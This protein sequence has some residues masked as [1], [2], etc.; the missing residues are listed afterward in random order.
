[1]IHVITLIR[2]KLITHENIIV[3]II[4]IIQKENSEDI[5]LICKQFQ[6]KHQLFVKPIESSELDIYVVEK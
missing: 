2:S 5:I 6:K 3:Q 1:M 4:N